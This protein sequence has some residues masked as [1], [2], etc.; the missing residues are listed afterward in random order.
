M[1][2]LCDHQSCEDCTDC[3]REFVKPLTQV[4]G[5]S[6]AVCFICPGLGHTCANTYDDMN[7]CYQMFVKDVDN[8]LWKEKAQ[9]VLD[10][11]AEYN[12]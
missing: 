9:K 12:K 1:S 10:R 8:P 4:L 7:K 6:R 2:D 3:P 5:F 11:I